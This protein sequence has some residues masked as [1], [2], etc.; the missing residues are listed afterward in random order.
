MPPFY[1]KKEIDMIDQDNNEPLMQSEQNG[2]TANS[3]S[4]RK[5]SAA[6]KRFDEILEWVEAFVFAGFIVLLVMTFVLRTVVVDGSSM[7]PTLYDSQRLVL[8]HFNYTPKRGDIIVANSRGLNKT[9]IKRCIGTSG[10]TVVIDYNENTVTVNGD[11]L[12]E[13]YLGEDMFELTMFDK[14]YQKSEGV[15]EYIVPDDCIFALGDNRN[16][17]RDSR[18]SEVG[19]INC[20][21]VLGRA[22]FRFY[23]GKDESGKSYPGTIGFL[24]G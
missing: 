6:A 21:D 1:R 20:D 7:N 17:S 15:Y 24:D 13:K 18:F 16:G 3:S 2:K 23:I 10:D 9:I 11:E 19:Y 14:T 4:E 12:D 8:E 5:D 22:F